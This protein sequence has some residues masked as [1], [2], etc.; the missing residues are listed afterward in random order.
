MTTNNLKPTLA[1]LA[2]DAKITDRRDGL[3][4][5]APQLD[6]VQMATTMHQNGAILSTITA[7]AIADNETEIVYHYWID[8]QAINIKVKTQN[9]AIQ[10]IAPVL[11]AANWIER[12]IHDLYSVD[13]INHPNLTR[14]LRPPQLAQG[15]FREPGGKASKNGAK[16]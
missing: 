13:F 16:N 14:L 10:S 5:I 9:N 8:K 7:S 12:E 3:W 11:H 4:M 1:A 15:L 6:V 2:G